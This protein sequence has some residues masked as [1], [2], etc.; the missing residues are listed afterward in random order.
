MTTTNE[1][2]KIDVVVPGC[3]IKNKEVDFDAEV[4]AAMGGSLPIGGFLVRPP[5]LGVFSLMETYESKFI[6]DPAECEV[7]EFWRVLY[8]NEHRQA[9]LQ[10]VMDWAYPDK[11]AL[12][13]AED[14]STWQ[15]FDWSVYDWA[16][17]V[18][19]AHDANDLTEAYMEAYKWFNLAFEGFDMI[20]GGEGNSECWFGADAIGS[21]SAALACSVDDVLWNISM[22][23][24][25]HK[26]AA[27]CK[28]NGNEHV[29]RK[30]DSDDM[31]LQF[32]EARERVKSGVMHPW[33]LED[34]TQWPLEP[35]Q[36]KHNAKLIDDWESLV[37]E[38]KNGRQH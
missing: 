28:Q 37:K 29:A 11:G 8:I 23:A 12:F 26:L 27:L 38:K 36:V 14:D 13:N 33:Q 18:G 34:P 30:K 3:F 20:P 4:Y 9:C 6:A 15:S 10:E 1:N 32:E 22:T 24:V 16:K 35:V 21:L 7:M 25:G 5:S 31:K 19:L 17:Q 2:E